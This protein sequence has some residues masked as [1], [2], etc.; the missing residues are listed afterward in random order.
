MTGAPTTG[1]TS[2]S[3]SSES[4]EEGEDDVDEDGDEDDPS[5]KDA[6]TCGFFRDAGVFFETS[7]SSE[8]ESDDSDDEEDDAWR[9]LR[10]LLRLRGAVGLAVGN[11]GRHIIITFF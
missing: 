1:G 2:S 7:A 4:D 11:Y 10:F 3:L 9:R 5:A 8:E 6:A